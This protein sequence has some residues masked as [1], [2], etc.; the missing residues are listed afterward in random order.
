MAWKVVLTNSAM[1]DL[2]KIFRHLF[3]AHRDGFGRTPREA[4]DLAAAR[5]KSVER[6]AARLATAPHRGTQHV[7]G[8]RTYR[9]VT[10]DRA[11]YWFTLDEP[12]ETVRVIGIFYGGQEHLDRMLG[13]LAGEGRGEDG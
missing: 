13:R 2:R 1:E 7:V 9:H 3:A 12:S 11:I 10:I 8:T 4:R 5:V 6:T